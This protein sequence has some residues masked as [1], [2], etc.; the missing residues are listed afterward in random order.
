MLSK[1]LVVGLL[2]VATLGCSGFPNENAGE[3][4]DLATSGEVSLPLTAVNGETNYRLANAKFTISGAPLRGAKI[5]LSPPA[6]QAVHQER[7]RVGSYAIELAAGWDFQRRGAAERE[8]VSVPATLVTS[9]PANFAITRNALSHVI[10]SF[11]TSGGQV[12]LGG[13]GV[14]QVEIQVRDCN[15]FN[16]VTAALGTF[17]VDCLGTLDPTQYS[18]GDDGILRRNFD[19]C[20]VDGRKLSSIDG[21]LSLQ[22]PGRDLHGAPDQ[23]PFAK[24]CVGG[25]WEIWRQQFVESGIAQCPVWKLNQLINAPNNE[26]V[27]RYASQLPQ[28][29]PRIG[30]PENGERPPVISQLRQNATYVVGFEGQVPPQQC[31]SPASCAAACA[32][33]FPGFVLGA[34]GEL[35]LTDP[36]YWELDTDYPD[37]AGEDP[38]MQGGYYHPMSFSGS[39]PGDIFGH[40]NRVGEPCSYYSSGYHFTTWMKDSCVE[41][42]WG[43]TVCVGMCRP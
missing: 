6:D 30:M 14:G 38:F 26:I 10:F 19:S 8:W 25:R 9:N 18:L 22:Y 3:D 29:S 11:A 33:G 27:A 13:A 36:P 41:D 43:G 24:E 39:I 7:L 23:M 32:G 15:S 28:I 16:G 1:L 21:I 20:P 17:T 34:D 37:P 31:D 2:S 42:E 12:V 35:V 5:E 40:F 4:S